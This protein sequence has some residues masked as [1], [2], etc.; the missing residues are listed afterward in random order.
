MSAALKASPANQA[1]VPSSPSRK[2][3]L[4][5]EEVEV[6]LELA[7]EVAAIDLAHDGADQRP[8]EKRRARL[9]DLREHELHDQQ[10]H[11]RAFGVMQP[12]GE[13]PARVRARR[14][15]EPALAV[16]LEHVLDDRA[17]LGHGQRAV[18]HDRRLAERMHLPERR[19]REQRGRVALVALD[20]VRDCELLEQPEH[21]LRARMVQVVD[22]Q[23]RRL[24]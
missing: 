15:R 1:P 5:L 19:R 18:G 8:H 7:I 2:S 20:L 17:G 24:T 10:R 6:Q 11:Q 9:A 14:R 23:H 13:A 12:V 4:A 3:R 22:G 21:A 16:A